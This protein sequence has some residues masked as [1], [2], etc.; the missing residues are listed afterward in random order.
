M[1]E[2]P[3]SVDVGIKAM[4]LRNAASWNAGRAQEAEKQE[5]LKTAQR[6][7]L[8]Y[9]A[10]FKQIDRLERVGDKTRGS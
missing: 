4:R 7:W 3:E 8:N 5:D 2:Q 1:D 10:L 6:Y 9:H